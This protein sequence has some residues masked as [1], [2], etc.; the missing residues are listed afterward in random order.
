[1]F[2]H[3]KIKLINSH[4]IIDGA[5]KILMDTG[6]PMSS[7]SSGV[8]CIGENKYNVQKNLPGI[9]F[10]YLKENIG[11]E[12]DGVLGMDIINVT[13]TLISLKNGFMFFDDDADYSFHLLMYPLPEY[14]SGLQAIT[15][16]V[17]NQRANMIVDS[18]A[19]I[20]YIQPKFLKGLS[21]EMVKDDFS[22]YVGNFTTETYICEVDCQT[23]IYSYYGIYKQ[24]FGIPPKNISMALNKL[25][26]DGIIGVDIFKQLRLQFRDG[27]LYLPSQGI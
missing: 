14:A 6:S 8:L 22:P 27:V 11:C 15:I 24:L 4:I 5:D 26:V 13:P 23:S 21:P 16:C 3:C 18:G 25:N 12:I 7:H 17:N 2:T 9:S 10:Q 20:S 1:M 19:P